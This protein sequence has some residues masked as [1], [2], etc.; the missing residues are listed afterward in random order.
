MS[1]SFIWPIDRT[2]SYASTP[3]QCEPWSNGNN[4][5]NLHSTK[6]QHHWSLNIRLF[7]V[8]SR[9][10]GV[11][12]FY[13]SAE[14]RSAYSTSSADWAKVVCMV[15]KNIQEIILFHILKNWLNDIWHNAY[16]YCCILTCVYINIYMQHHNDTINN[17][18]QRLL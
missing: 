15:N 3:G 14:M 9:T 8:I 16:P 12:G 10:L 18:E 6:L 13:G 1:S 17:D 4:E 11:G 7:S 2:L 5:V